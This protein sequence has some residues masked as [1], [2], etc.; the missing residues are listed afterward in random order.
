MYFMIE[1]WDVEKYISNVKK[2]QAT[3]KEWQKHYLLIYFAYKV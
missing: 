1:I 3:C 2:R